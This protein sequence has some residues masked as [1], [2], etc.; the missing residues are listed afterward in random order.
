MN[1]AHFHKPLQTPLLVTDSPTHVERVRGTLLKIVDLGIWG[2]IFVAPLFFGGR[3]GLGRFVLVLLASGTALA[4]LILQMF[5]SRGRW[6]PSLAYVVILLAM[7]LVLGQLIPLPGGWLDVLTP[8][9]AELLPAWTSGTDFPVHLGSW[10]TISLTPN[11]TRVSLAILW[12]LSLVF[13][14]VANRVRTLEDIERIL[15][16]IAVAAIGMACFG[17]LQYLTSNGCFFWFYEYPYRNTIDSVNGPFTNRN[18]FSHFIVLGFSPL[19]AWIFCKY[20]RT[21]LEPE[22]PRES[23]FHYLVLPFLCLGGVA[24]IW[25]VLQSL[26]RGGT[27]CLLVAAT[28]FLMLLWYRGMIGIR[29]LGGMVG[30]FVVIVVGIFPLYHYGRV[31]ERLGDLTSGSVE[32]IDGGRG[33]RRVWNAN[34]GAIRAGW[35]VGAGAG[36]HRYI[37][38]IYLQDPLPREYS[39]AENG[40]LQLVTE[41]GLPGL[42]LLV[43]AIGL[44][45]RWCLGALR[46]AS[47]DRVALCTAAV[48]AGIVASLFHS[49]VD[50]VW[51]IPACATVTVVLAACGL[52][53]FQLT[54]KQPTSLPASRQRWFELSAATIIVSGWMLLITA[55]PAQAAVHWDRYKLALVNRS[56][57]VNQQLSDASRTQNRDLERQQEAL[58]AE[59]ISELTQ[60][61]K[62]DPCFGRGHVRLARR[63]LE[64]FELR[65]K[66]ADNAMSVSQ[67]RDAAIASQF[68][69][70]AALREWLERAFG[71]NANLLY[72]AHAHALST[73]RIC[74]LE[75][76]AYLTLADLCFLEGRGRNEIAGFI[77]QS[78]RVSP[79][80]GDILFEV[81]KQLL[82]AGQIEKALKTWARCYRQPGQHRIK[83]V[84]LLAG[85]LP[86]GNFLANFDPDWQTLWHVWGRYQELGQ[87]EDLPLLVEHAEVMTKKKAVETNPNLAAKNFVSLSYMQRQLD[88]VDDALASLHTAYRLT[89]HNYSVRYSLGNLL[90]K[91]KQYH[92]AKPHLRWCL[93]RKPGAK[94]LTKGLLEIARHDVKNSQNPVAQ[95]DG[96]TIGNH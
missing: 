35:G 56:Q 92:A 53:L 38:S 84:E 32:E 75:G 69:S 73:A 11:Q 80:D 88:Q 4:W 68:K 31:V 60:V 81:G 57:L 47:S 7:V 27:I 94:S 64:Q 70:P 46:R 95:A 1:R 22:K 74:P 26:S 62:W 14:V 13:I 77:Q 59:M 90:L 34:G 42:V 16:W 43:T 40:Y 49:M 17:I 36:S 25:A 2:L 41:N 78:E 65:Q 30:L 20:Q 71:Q 52:R 54:S 87:P 89:P 24:I 37:H 51:Y 45:C 10:Q 33:R 67:I 29:H 86:A 55:G 15:R 91:A 39:H 93:A 8:R 50:F 76:K 12:A 18:H 58:T 85:R 28:T 63:Y 82:M 23:R 21:P 83:V 44:V 3:H 19:L 66:Y 79:Y 48:S 9:H 6:Q 96:T 61:V 5:E 72:Q